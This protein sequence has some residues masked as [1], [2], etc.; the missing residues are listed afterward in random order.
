MMSSME[1]VEVVEAELNVE[2][3]I[4]T[5]LKEALR[6]HAAEAAQAEVRG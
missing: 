3:R 5:E 1:V 4:A 2:K 6:L